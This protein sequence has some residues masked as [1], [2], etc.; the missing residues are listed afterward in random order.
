[1]K[2]SQKTLVQSCAEG[3]VWCHR[4]YVIVTASQSNLWVTLLRAFPPALECSV[5]RGLLQAAVGAWSHSRQFLQ[6]SM[7]SDGVKCVFFAV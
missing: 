1:M 2:V 7:Y 3:S 4:R 5:G 6:R